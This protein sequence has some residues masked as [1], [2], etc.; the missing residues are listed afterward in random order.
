MS[1]F[2]FL[3]GMA[4][5]SFGVRNVKILQ[6]LSIVV[7]I[8]AFGVSL[9]HTATP[10]VGFETPSSFILFELVLFVVTIATLLHL[11]QTIA[12]TQTL[13]LVA[14]ALLVL[15]SNT[16]VSFVI[17][18]ESLSIVSFILVSFIRTK[19]EAQGA[20]KMF[21]SGSVA[22]AII[23]LGVALYLLEGH[24]LLE[25]VSLEVKGFGSVGIWLILFGVF[26][27]LTIVPMHTWAA[28]SYAEI[29]PANSAILSGIA[30]TVVFVA[31]FKT[32]AP[33]LEKNTTFSEPILLVL[34]LVTITL[35]NFLALF[36]K[37]ITKILSYS[38]IAHAGY[39]LLAFVSV[40]SAYAQNALLYMAI[41]YIFMQTALFLLVD[42]LSDSKGELY[43]E[44]LKALGKKD[45]LSALFFSVQLFSLA[46]IPL[47]AGFLAK[48][49]MVYALVDV[50]LVFVA[51]FVLLNS[52]LS[53]GYYASIVRYFYFE[54]ATKEN[55]INP[56]SLKVYFAQAIFLAGTLFFGV[57]AGVVFEF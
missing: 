51:L 2:V 9:M 31:T 13:F 6:P 50:N 48:A 45:K 10:L 43:L 57:F 30:K 4:L 46:G 8:A 33:F 37:E 15:E 38:S 54:D 19:K 27:K 29:S 24:S 17:A 36:S 18:F 23:V 28:D 25:A 55:K 53:V 49:V 32:F 12:I 35:G 20:I 14:T 22:T 56:I 26:Y 34:A 16:L 3:F 1:P 44:D 11:E 47:L 52:A 40:K 21:I 41:A 7:V 5:L 42:K 39:M